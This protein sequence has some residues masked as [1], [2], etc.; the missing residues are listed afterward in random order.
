[1]LPML[2]LWACGPNSI[3]EVDSP[4]PAIDPDALLAATQPLTDIGPRMVAM[5]GEVQAFEQILTQLRNEGLEPTI[6]PFTFDAWRPGTATL[7]V[8]DQSFEV[9]A[10][11]PTPDTD[12]TAAL[13]L[14]GDAMAGNIGLYS[15]RDGPRSVQFLQAATQDAAG[16][17]R[18]TDFLDDDGTPL[19]EVG[20]TIEGGTLPGVGVDQPTGDILRGHIGDMV[21]LLIDP[22][23]AVGHESY[24]IVLRFGDPEATRRVWVT[25]HYDSWYN[26]EAAFDNALGVGAL[27]LLARRMPSLELPDVEVVFLATSGEEQGL[28]GAFAWVEEREHLIGPADLAITLDVLWSGDGTFQCMGS[29]EARLDAAMAAHRDAGLDPTDGGDPGIASDHFPFVSRGAEAIWCGRWPDKHYH[30]QADLLEHIDMN[31]ASK[32]VNAHWQLIVDAV[33]G[34]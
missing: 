16:W 3:E 6:D 19:L 27:V 23:I 13:V 12:L 28:Q 15:S 34:P 2:L 26:S 24:N 14:D 4:L 30:T 29:T 17:I 25:A 21:R 18:I 5:P 8:G 31:Q 7:E 10:M 1:M 20:H 11:S 22:N 32:V 9:Q 33:E